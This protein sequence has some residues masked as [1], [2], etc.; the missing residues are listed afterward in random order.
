[1]SE[2]RFEPLADIDVDGAVFQVGIHHYVFGPARP[3]IHFGTGCVDITINV[4]RGDIDTMV[5][6][7]KRAARQIDKTKV[8]L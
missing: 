5:N 1:M 7:L 8:G 3:A 6:A 4:H 2:N